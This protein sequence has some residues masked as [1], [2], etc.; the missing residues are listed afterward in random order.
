MFWSYA[1]YCNVC[2]LEWQFDFNVNMYRPKLLERRRINW[3]VK[4]YTG[5]QIDSSSFPWSN[6]GR[7][8]RY[9]SNQAKC[10]PLLLVFLWCALWI[11]LIKCLAFCLQMGRC[12][13]GVTHNAC[14]WMLSLI[15][16][17]VVLIQSAMNNIAWCGIWDACRQGGPLSPKL[18][19]WKQVLFRPFFSKDWKMCFI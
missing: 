16:G 4:A 8:G 18:D 15:F 1:S 17:Q 10:S 13:I 2:G 5:I 6:Q 9:W 3:K 19:Q 12:L 11:L 7:A 14:D